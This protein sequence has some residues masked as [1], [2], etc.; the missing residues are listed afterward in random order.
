ML[1][2]YLNKSPSEKLQMPFFSLASNL[3]AIPYINSTRRISY[4]I[5]LIRFSVLQVFGFQLN[6]V[7]D[8]LIKMIKYDRYRCWSFIDICEF[9]P[10]FF[11]NL[12]PPSKTHVFNRRKSFVNIHN[13]N[14]DRVKRMEM[15]ANILV[16]QLN[17]FR[18]SYVSEIPHFHILLLHRRYFVDILA[19]HL[20]DP[21]KKIV[22]VH[23]YKAYT[24]Y[25]PCENK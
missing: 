8:S 13:A 21:K 19:V 12:G 5:A 23:C 4:S 2:T 22:V 10:R 1:C 25:G 18:T 11:R 7:Y 6:N 9:L 17:L 24:K 3:E 14:R 15:H 16:G 20:S